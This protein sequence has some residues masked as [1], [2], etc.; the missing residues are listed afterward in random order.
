[1]EEDLEMKDEVSDHFSSNYEAVEIK[2]GLVIWDYWIIP[3]LP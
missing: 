1:M 2:E 3:V